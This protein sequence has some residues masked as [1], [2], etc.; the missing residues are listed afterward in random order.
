MSDVNPYDTIQV[1]KIRK[2][3]AAFRRAKRIATGWP[4]WKQD[5]GYPPMSNVRGR[6]SL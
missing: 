6:R 1:A 5:V 2:R 3:N 4:K